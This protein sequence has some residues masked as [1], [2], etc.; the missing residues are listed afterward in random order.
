MQRFHTFEEAQSFISSA[1]DSPV[2]TSTVIIQ[3]GVSLTRSTIEMEDD[4]FTNSYDLTFNGNDHQAEIVAFDALTSV[5][6]FMTESDNHNYHAAAAGGFF[7]LADKAS[8]S[9][10]QLALNLSIS[11]GHVRSLPVSDRESVIAGHNN[12]E[13]R[14]LVSLG[15]LSLNGRELDWSGSLTDYDTELKVFSNGNAKI[16]REQDP[17]T[18]SARVLDDSSRYTPVIGHDDYIDV[19]F[20]GRDR[21]NFIGVSGST[22]GG[23]D[24][25]AHDFVLRCPQSYIEG[26][27]ELEI[28]TIGGLA[29]SRFE[30]GAFSAGPAL[31]IADFHNHPINR[32]KSLGNRPPFLETR[33][34]RTV[35]YK[36]DDDLTHIRLFDGRPGS[37]TFS[38]MTP[39]E[40]VTQLL[41]EKGVEWGCFLDPG[42]TAKLCIRSEDQIEEYGNRHYL[43]WPNEANSDFLWVPESGRPVAN[44]IAI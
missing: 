11:R 44:V 6:D 20:I 10:R 31:N 33:L 32:D 27:S 12:L 8:G 1:V 43:R 41:S 13:V 14:F 35:L 42:Q 18:G 17:I 25:F 26:N 19:G 39:N 5:Y 28:H 21:N 4:R 7:Y 23:V 30:G 2:S 9:P 22:T 3:P 36:S 38:G 16:N 24:I 15:S 29:L 37:Q 40:T 34:A